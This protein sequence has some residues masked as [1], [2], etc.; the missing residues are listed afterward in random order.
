MMKK[1]PEKGI[2]SFVTDVIV[3]NL[4][5]GLGYQLYLCF[6]AAL[7]MLGIYAYFIQI[8]LGLAA[9]NLSNIVNTT[10]VNLMKKNT[11]PLFLFQYSGSLESTW[12]PPFC[13]KDFPPGLFGT[14][15]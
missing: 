9:T 14:I 10:I 2:I 7:T 3:W 1:S 13:I 6:L 8:N 4:S 12:L 15:R 5:G 11:A